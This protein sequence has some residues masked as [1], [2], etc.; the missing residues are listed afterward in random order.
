[1]RHHSAPASRK[2]NSVTFEFVRFCGQ[3]SA[4]TSTVLEELA[5]YGLM[6]E[7]QSEA[8]RKT[9]L[10]GSVVAA[11]TASLCCIGPLV[12]VAIGASGFAAAGFF[13]KWRPFLLASTFALLG[14]AWFLTY[15]KSKQ[16]CA[17]GSCSTNPVARWNRVVLWMATAAV[18]VSAA[19]PNLSSALLRKES[20]TGESV[21]FTA[22]NVLKV[23][24]PSMDCAA[25]AAS[26]RKTLSAEAG[27]RRAD[28]SFD[29]K[30]AVVYYDANRI[31][32]EEVIATINKTG[33]KA[34]P[35][36]ETKEP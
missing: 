22:A 21:N 14:L 28:V 15:R 2:P 32:R 11:I 5:W 35:L 4:C 3:N 27:V 24:I 16:Q 10:G 33:F 6:D 26:I 17:D 34:E 23:R 36:I 31:S 13:T 9:S 18:F 1:M 25:C 7:R 12:A 29:T 19:F 8:L 30:D 20:A